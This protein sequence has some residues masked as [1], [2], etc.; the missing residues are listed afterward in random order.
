MLEIIKKLK[1]TQILEKS[2]QSNIIGGIDWSKCV[3]PSVYCC[4]IK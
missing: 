1:N 2:D 3:C 4:P